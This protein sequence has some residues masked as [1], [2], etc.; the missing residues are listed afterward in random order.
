MRK[1]FIDSL[2]VLCILILFPFHTFMIYNN[3]GEAFYIHGESIKCLSYFNTIVYPWWMT[4]LFTLAGISSAY[5]LKR[6]TYQEYVKERATKL[7]VPLVV[8]IIFIIPIQS[9]IAD[10]FHNQYIG[11]VFEHYYIFFTKLTDISGYDGGFTP[12]HTWFLLYLFIIS[13]LMIPIM[14]WYRKKE[15]K[16]NKNKITIPKLLPFFLVIL[17]A[18]PIGD[19]GGKSIGEFMACFAIGYF[20]LSLDQVQEKLKKSWIWLV[21]LFITVIILRILLFNLNGGKGLIFD[22]EQR[23]VTWFGILALMGVGKKFLDYPS[24]VVKYLAGAS[25]SLYYFHQTFIVILGYYVLKYVHNVVLQISTIIV[26]SFLLSVI[27]YEICKRVRVLS[28]LFGVKYQG[29]KR[30]E[31][32]INK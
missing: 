19:I 29:I 24:K 32:N 11:N 23:M 21:C 18:T 9:Y 2:R 20:V 1:Y 30:V 14:N 22:I 6:R 26:G 16:I 5:S 8:G 13:I 3:W 10:C 15:K 31:H 17:L 25:F 7:F 28:F 12:A 4:L 27:A